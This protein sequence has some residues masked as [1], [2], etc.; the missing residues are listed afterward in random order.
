MSSLSLCRFI[1]PFIIYLRIK[2]QSSSF[3]TLSPNQKDKYLNKKRIIN[4]YCCFIFLY[5][6]NHFVD[7][8]AHQ[9][10]RSPTTPNYHRIRS[11][12]IEFHFQRC[13][14]HETLNVYRGPI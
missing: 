2:L 9:R 8:L 12:I 13:R 1:S 11:F 7:T 6:T 10:A 14:V 5:N 3:L 4:Y